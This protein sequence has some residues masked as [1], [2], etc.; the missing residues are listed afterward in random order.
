MLAAG[1]LRGVDCEFDRGRTKGGLSWLSW[2]VARLGGW[3]CYGKKP[4][5]KTIAA[6]WH[7]LS[8]ML[9]GYRLANPTKDV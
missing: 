8:A 4:G 2:V 5:P 3:N 6:A 9:D 7:R 1:R